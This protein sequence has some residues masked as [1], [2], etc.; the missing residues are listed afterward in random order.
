MNIPVINRFESAT[1]VGQEHMVLGWD[2]Q[3][4]VTGYELKVEELNENG[5]VKNTSTYKTNKNSLKIEKVNGYSTYRV[6]IQSLNGTEWKVDTKMNKK[7][8]K[9]L[10]QVLLT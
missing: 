6:S 10:L 5:T 8:T 7:V 9:K 2:H 1:A 4:N 3:P